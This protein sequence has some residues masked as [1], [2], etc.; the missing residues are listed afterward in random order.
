MGLLDAPAPQPPDDFLLPFLRLPALRWLVGSWQRQTATQLTDDTLGENVIDIHNGPFSIR[1]NSNGVACADLEGQSQGLIIPASLSDVPAAGRSFTLIYISEPIGAVPV[2]G[3]WKDFGSAASF[4]LNV[5]NS[6]RG[7]FTI[8]SGGADIRAQTASTAAGAG[9]YFLAGRWKPD[10]GVENGEVY[11]RLNEQTANAQTV[12]N[13]IDASAQRVGVATRTN[14]S[15][16]ASEFSDERFALAAWIDGYLSN[17][18][19]EALYRHA[20]KFG[21]AQ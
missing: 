17:D 11:C 4:S 10:N 16:V 20:L 18:H 1:T 2:K 8:V 5:N 21:Y 7:A 15:S 19:L 14:Q 12:A 13:S 9:P 6:A 3:I